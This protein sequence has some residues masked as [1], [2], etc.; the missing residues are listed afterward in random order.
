MYRPNYTI[1]PVINRHIAQIERTRVL[2]EKST[3]LPSQEIILRRRALVEATR[4]STGIEGNPLNKSEIE[5]VFVGKHIA[6][7]Q[8]FISEV[9]NYKKAL[10]FIRARATRKERISQKDILHLHALTMKGLLES[11]KIGAYR[12]TP[13]YVVD[14]SPK[15]EDVRY[16]G[17][18]PD[19]VVSLITD[20][21]G[22]IGGVGDKLHPVLIA[23]ILHYE[24]VSIH[25]F[26]DGNGRLTRLLTMLYLYK[27]GYGLRNVLVPEIYYFANR[28]DYYNALNQ[29]KTYRKQSNADQTLWLEY[30]TTGLYTVACE[31]EQK[32]AL[33]SLLPIVKTN[34]V[35]TMDDKDFR[36]V[37]FVLTM[38]KV[39]VQDIIDMLEIP[40]RTAQRKL[41][42][43]KDIGILVQKGRGPASHYVVRK[44]VT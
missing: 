39:T 24:F 36:V 29:A 38:K 14:I 9:K 13:I 19:T 8:R 37:D 42:R 28:Q 34:K 1:S 3:I 7:Q 41:K 30:F 44:K 26:A 43:L 15:C 27:K 4:S 31:V 21:L 17:P 20:L 32:I 35:V 25:P 6:V 11:S 18:A 2:V 40:K 5:E 22:W 33:A 10:E 16:K 23:G 12:K